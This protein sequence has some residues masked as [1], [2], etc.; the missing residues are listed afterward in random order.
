M[1]PKL[2]LFVLLLAIALAVALV[3][4]RQPSTPASNANADSLANPSTQAAAQAAATAS[5]STK[6]KSADATPGDR[7]LATLAAA[8]ITNSNELSPEERHQAY[9]E[10]RVAELSDLGFEED[11]DSL[12]NILSDLTN[13]D[14]EIRDAAREAAVQFGSKDAIP[15]LTLALQQ[16]DDVDE[17]TKF[18]EAIDFL[19]LPSINDTNRVPATVENQ[20]AK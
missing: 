15:A 20:T 6:P 9:I 1:R 17:R 13:P 19:K 18:K 14:E 11:A 8:G 4:F 12:N 5:T 3:F 7:E 2:V 16:L 10:A